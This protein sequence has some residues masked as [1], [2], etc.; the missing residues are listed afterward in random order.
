ML[1]KRYIPILIVIIFCFV[2]CP[3]INAAP[4][5][6]EECHMK[7]TPEQVKDFNRG[8]MS[9]TIS[10]TECHGDSH[11]G[12]DD[13]SKALLPTIATCEECHSDQAEQYL[14]G[15][16]ALGLIAMEAMLYTH[17]QPKSFIEGQKG[18]ASNRRRIPG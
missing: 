17:M 4:S 5:E 10:C 3:L 7:I 14:N 1:K 8:V 9:E 12:K 15:K 6:C 11:K 16:H 18:C 13:I 2:N